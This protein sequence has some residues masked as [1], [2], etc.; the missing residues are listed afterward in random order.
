[1]PTERAQAVAFS[2]LLRRHNLE[3]QDVVRVKQMRDIQGQD[4]QRKVD[5]GKG[6]GEK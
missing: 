5:S 1:M 3:N 6:Q 4:E 2:L